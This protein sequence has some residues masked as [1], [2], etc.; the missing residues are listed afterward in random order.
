MNSDEILELWQQRRSQLEISPSFS[1]KVMNRIFE[2]KRRRS[3]A[4]FDLYRLIEVISSSRSA[5]A[6]VMALGAATGIT[7]AAIV[8]LS[9][10]AF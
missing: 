3:K 6:A 10:L 7:R 1:D 8:V 9:F 2:H 4:T 5:T